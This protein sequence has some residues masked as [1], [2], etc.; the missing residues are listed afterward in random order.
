MWTIAIDRTESTDAS[1]TNTGEVTVEVIREITR[2][3]LAGLIAGIVVGGVGGRLVMRL[4][5]VLVPGA[6]GGRTD[7]G[8]LIGAIT[9]EG[10]LALFLFGGLA[11]GIFAGSIWVM[12]APWLPA[13]WPTR[14]LAGAIIA[15]AI[16]TPGLVNAIVVVGLATL[17]SWLARDRGRPFGPWLGIVTRAA[18]V[19]TAVVGLAASIPQ[20]RGALLI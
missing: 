16:G 5:A 20:I 14:A 10:T 6:V 15:A 19:L 1:G 7:N 18:L 3:G 13:A 8:A 4:A 11:A 17:L 9:I 12:V 2:G